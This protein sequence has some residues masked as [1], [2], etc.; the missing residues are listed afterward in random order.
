[1]SFTGLYIS[2]EQSV[3]Y[4][5][6]EVKGGKCHEEKTDNRAGNCRR[7]IYR[8]RYCKRA[9]EYHIPADVPERDKDDAYR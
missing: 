1:M 7:I 5:Q 8:N 2:P 6:T 9:D 4:V 3:R